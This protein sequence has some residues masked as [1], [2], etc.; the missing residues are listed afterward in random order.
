MIASSSL[1][2]STSFIHPFIPLKLISFRLI[3]F[4][5]AITSFTTIR[6]IRWSY[7]DS[8]AMSWVIWQVVTVII[9]GGWQWS[10]YEVERPIL[11]MS[12]YLMIRSVAGAGLNFEKVFQIIALNAIIQAS[13][14]MLQYFGLFP[15][16]SQLFVGFESQVTGTLGG[17]NVLGA[18]LGT[19]LPMIYYCL[20]RSIGSKR[21]FWIASLSLIIFTMILT[22]SRGAWIASLVG[23]VLYLIPT[24]STLVRTIWSRKWMVLIIVPAGILLFGLFL[25]ALYNLNSAS[26]DG[27]IFIWSVTMD[28][29]SDHFLL[30][31][32]YGNF[33]L[34]WLEYQGAY[35][36]RDLTGNSHSLAVSLTSAHSQYLHIIA[37]TGIIGL[38]LFCG[39][40]ISLLLTI[41][42]KLRALGNK[43]AKLI[44]ALT[45]A[46]LMLLIHGIV[47]DVLVGLPVEIMF[48]IIIALLANLTSCSNASCEKPQASKIRILQILIIPLLILAARLGYQEVRGEL[49]WKQGRDLAHGGRWEDGIE[50]YRQA[51]EYLP[52]NYELE[53]YLGAAYAK[54][55]EAGLGIQHLKNS[56][57]GLKDK[58]QC[59][60]L[61]KAYLDNGDYYLAEASLREALGYYPMLLNPHYWLS[62]CYFEQGDV[63]G[64]RDELLIIIEADNEFNS[65]EIEIVM[66]DARK[67]LAALGRAALK[68]D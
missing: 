29:I 9:S 33:G 31:V 5:M 57:A 61:G 65:G 26:A 47:E 30:G 16:T 39:M 3:V 60:A 42:R 41:K 8:F 66:A 63:E 37:E 19:S 2:F 58:N 18:L 55:G 24:I 67:A 38:T 34:H 43:K 48:I 27:R 1:L 4:G 14:G 28:M 6:H 54:I 15:W 45:A 7:I 40:V 50:K 17:A 10:L 51:G 23:L 20:S 44:M 21:M 68:A 49:L 35:F 32:G 52:G 13:I 11:L 22:K 56:E 36:A 53:F 64:A 25:D 62:R 59:I 46:L 12:F